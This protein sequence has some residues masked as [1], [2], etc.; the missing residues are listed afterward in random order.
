MN[1]MGT[2]NLSSRDFEKTFQFCSALDILRMKARY[3]MDHP[4]SATL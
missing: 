4:N 2:P 3:G 1:D